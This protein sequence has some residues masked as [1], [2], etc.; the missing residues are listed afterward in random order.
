MPSVIDEDEHEKRVILTDESPISVSNN[1]QTKF[2]SALAKQASIH[3][4]SKDET[5]TAAFKYLKKC[6]NKNLNKHH[7][8]QLSN[9]LKSSD[10]RNEY[11]DLLTILEDMSNENNQS[12]KLDEDTK[13]LV[14]KCATTETEKALALTAREK[15]KLEKAKEDARQYTAM[16]NKEIELQQAAQVKKEQELME[17]LLRE[18]AKDKLEEDIDDPSEEKEDDDNSDTM[19]PSPKEE[20][21]SESA[22]EILSLFSQVAARYFDQYVWGNAKTLVQ[23]LAGFTKSGLIKLL[24]HLTTLLDEQKK[25]H[26]QAL[27]EAEDYRKQLANIKRV[28]GKQLTRKKND[29]KESVQLKHHEQ[30]L[31]QKQM[32]LEEMEIE[33]ANRKMLA[34]LE[35]NERYQKEKLEKLK[36]REKMVLNEIGSRT[37]D[38]NELPASAEDAEQEPVVDGIQKP[39]DTDLHDELTEEQK[40]F[41]TNAAKKYIAVEGSPGNPKTAGNPMECTFSND[42]GGAAYAG[43]LTDKMIDWCDQNEYC[44][45][46]NDRCRFASRAR[47]VGKKAKVLGETATHNDRNLDS[48]FKSEIRKKFT[49]LTK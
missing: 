45:M 15:N 13:R 31:L 28:Y 41:V 1:N 4:A 37:M 11:Q 10:K 47:D 17:K 12:F 16:L 27:K 7:F 8:M 48:K 49:E 26:Q 36:A 46:S 21:E 23:Y 3:E 6:A 40:K 39:V 24:N 18:R 5:L 2:V 34:K 20:D 32:E 29:A 43:P 42:D 30:Q 9:I 22:L 35:R 44:V 33:E 14:I 19:D 38:T 25:K